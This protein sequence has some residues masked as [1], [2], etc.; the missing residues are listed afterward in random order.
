MCHCSYLVVFPKVYLVMDYIYICYFRASSSSLLLS[1]LSPL[2]FEYFTKIFNKFDYEKGLNF[3]L[4]SRYFYF[5][6]SYQSAP[7]PY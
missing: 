6:L 1:V 4:S 7:A 5:N 3:S 2:C